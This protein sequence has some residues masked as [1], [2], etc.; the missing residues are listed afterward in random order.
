MDDSSDE[1]KPADTALVDRLGTRTIVL[2]GLM[3][4]GKTSVGKRLAAKLQLPFIDAD[5]EIEKAAN[6]TIPEIF[7]KH[8]EAYFRDGER[9]VIRRLLDGRPKVLATGGGAFMSEETREAIAAGAISIWLRADL[10]ILMAR[11]RK[12]SNRPL[13]QTADPEATMRGLM[14]QRYPVYA[15]ADIH[16]LSRDVAHDVVADETIRAIDAFLTE[17]EAARRNPQ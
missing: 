11:V 14:D 7:A 3:G 4:A 17:E 12:R 6:A 10:D 16:I 2:V 5:A 1:A 9:R 15:K 8:G 13:L